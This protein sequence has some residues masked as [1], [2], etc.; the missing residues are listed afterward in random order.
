MVGAT[1]GTPEG[2][3]NSV[4]ATPPGPINIVIGLLERPEVV[5][6]MVDDS[7]AKFENVFG[8]KVWVSTD[9]PIVV[10]T[11]VPLGGSCPVALALGG[12][13]ETPDLGL[14]GVYARLTVTVRVLLWELAITIV[15]TAVAEES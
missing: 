6:V 7:V 2:R 5:V 1:S 3:L 15:M 11:T 4:H 10:V 9:E 14:R 12:G 13:N 8:T